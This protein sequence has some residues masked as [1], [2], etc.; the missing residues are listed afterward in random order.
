MSRGIL[1]S[2][3]YVRFWRWSMVMLWRHGRLYPLWFSCPAY[4]EVLI[5][6]RLPVMVLTLMLVWFV[7]ILIIIYLIIIWIFRSLVKLEAV[8]FFI[9]FS[10][11]LY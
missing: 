4:L 10:V 8:I 7:I 1:F 6:T 9:E 2:F 5:L 3:P 11:F